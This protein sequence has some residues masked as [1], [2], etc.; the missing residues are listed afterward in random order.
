MSDNCPEVDISLLKMNDNSSDLKKLID[1]QWED[2]SLAKPKE[3]TKSSDT[4]YF[5][6]DNVLV[7]DDPGL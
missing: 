4:D 5:Y 7:F 2:P 6:K 1:E 3:L